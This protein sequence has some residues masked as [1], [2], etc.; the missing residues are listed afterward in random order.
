MKGYCILYRVTSNHSNIYGE[1]ETLSSKNWTR[2]AEGCGFQV[3]VAVLFV[4]WWI[5]TVVLAYRLSYVTLDAVL[6]V[7][8]PFPLDF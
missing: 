7:C 1:N 5:R 6:G 4:I 8:V 3:S 2:T